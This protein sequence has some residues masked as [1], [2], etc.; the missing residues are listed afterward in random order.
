M[1]KL[2]ALLVLV[3]IPGVLAQGELHF[4]NWSGYTSEE[5]LAKFTEETGIKVVLDT[6][7]SN[8]TLL[9]KLKSGNTGYDLVVPTHNF[10][11]IFLQEGLLEPINASE[12][13]N[14]KNLDARWQNP[15]WDPGN[16]YTVPWQWG[17]TS[18][19]VDTDIYGGDI[20][21]Y[22]V[23]F[24]P[25]TELQGK[26]NMFN[27]WDEVLPMALRYL[28]YETCTTDTEA[29]SKMLDMLEAQRP[30]VK[31][32]T[33]EGIL[34]SMIAGEYA[35]STYWNGA[36]MR[37]RNERPSA[38]YAYPKEGVSGWMDN[39]AVAKGAPN[40]EAALTFINWFLQPEN[41]AMESN[42]ARYGNGVVGA[43]AFMDEQLQTAPEIVPPADADIK[44]ALTCPP[45]YNDLATRL[46]TRLKQ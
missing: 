1:K 46:W 39:L 20:D 21:T 43:E 31:T 15:G 4:Y 40:K 5:M 25:P 33:S 11:P 9:A 8:E 14:Y 7:D 23:L 32:Y 44:F 16:V 45:E 36:S 27:S 29:F 41:A 10:V 35:M 12:M 19:I 3:I 6:F 38:Q 24:E 37:V 18:F 34:D 22:K 17:T 13:E 26:I 30:Y 2:L 42:F 28:G